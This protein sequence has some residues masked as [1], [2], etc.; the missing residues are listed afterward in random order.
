MSSPAGSGTH[1]AQLV[2]VGGSHTAD[3]VVN[4]IAA[5]EGAPIPRWL[6]PAGGVYQTRGRATQLDPGNYYILDTGEPEGDNVKGYFETGAVA[7]LEVTGELRAG[8]LPET[9]AK[10]TAEDHTITARGLKG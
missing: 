5:G 6:T 1:D 10:V 2:R 3:E 4:A 7:A 9:D 8:K